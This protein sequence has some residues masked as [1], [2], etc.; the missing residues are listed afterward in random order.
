MALEAVRIGAVTSSNIYKAL[1]K[2]HG[3]ST[4]LR[5]IANKHNQSD[6]KLWH[7]AVFDRLGSVRIDDG[8]RVESRMIEGKRKKNEEVGYVKEGI[9]ALKV[10]KEV[11][12]MM[13]EWR[14][15]A[16][17]EMNRTGRF[18]RSL[19]NSSTDWPIL[20]MEVL[21]EAAE[22]DFF[23]PKLVINN[24]DVLRR[25]TTD[26]DSLVPG[27]LYHDSFIWRVIALGI[28]ERCLPV[29]LVT[30]DGYYSH[31]AFMDLGFLDA[32]ISREN[33]GWRVQEAKWHMVPDYF[34]ETEWKVIEEVLGTN[35]RQL[36]EMYSLKQ[37]TP[38]KETIQDRNT[39][40]DIVDAYLA[41]LQVTVVNPAMECAVTLLQ[42]FA[43]DVREGKIPETKLQ[44]GVPWRHP[45]RNDDP[46][47]NL[48]WAKIQLM[49]FVQSLV[50]AEFGMNYLAEVTL[51]ILDDPST[52]ALMEVG[53]LYSQR[54]P[55]F[56]R[57]ITRGIERCLARWLVHE[58]LQMSFH[59]YLPYLWQRLI[60]GRSY[61]HL[62]KEVGYK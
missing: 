39:F 28:N 42:K 57:P 8:G 16:V 62:M 49:D 47:A 3:V 2:Y 40:E 20:L 24:I 53:I 31:Q 41:Y 58:K 50:N 61:R 37:S 7:K 52:I 4:A 22:V 17:R 26:E 56:L 6:I 33:F 18:S 32:F 15:E 10:A 12:G 13:Q 25:A 46:A 27:A 60:R 9:A 11:I 1:N 23:Q 51:E 59:D 5:R 14:K 38:Y 55:S 35:P 36:S 45:P 43:S 34:S 29:I 30:S 21:S 48:K 44:F 54:E 19:V